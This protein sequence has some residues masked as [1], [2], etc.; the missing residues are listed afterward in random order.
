MLMLSPPSHRLP[1]DLDGVVD[2]GH[3]DM[4]TITYALWRGI[5]GTVS[6]LAAFIA[7][8]FV[9][10]VEPVLRVVALA[11]GGVVVPCI[12]GYSI[13]LSVRIKRKQLSAPD[14]KHTRSASA[15]EG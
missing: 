11:V 7:P 3:S 10:N 4:T 6:G 2:S 13:W 14:D 1:T 15:E 5:T 12:T 8:A 9:T